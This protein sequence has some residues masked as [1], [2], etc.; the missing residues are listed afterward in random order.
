MKKYLRW[1]ILAVSLFLIVS[2]GRS[3]LQIFGR[4]NALEEARQRIRELEEEQARLLE[5][6][7][8][9]ESQEF[10]EKEAREKLG[11]AKPGEVVVIL[12][13]DE[14][15]RKLAPDFDTEHFAEELPIY[16]RWMRLFF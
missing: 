2:M 4:G 13:P 8:K 16:K 5:L 15:L 12:P 9:V 3:T 7:E 1:I 14:A 10:M 11:L 6:K